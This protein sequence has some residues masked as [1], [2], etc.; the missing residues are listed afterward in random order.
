MSNE[1]TK[2]KRGRKAGST[3]SINVSI[4]TLLK[5]LKPSTVIPVRRTWVSNMETFLGVS[6]TEDEK[7]KVEEVPA[8][9]TPTPARVVVPM[10]E[11][12]L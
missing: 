10:V 1:A 8:E 2:Q 9:E 5:H 12:E 11:E 3:D 7:P 6:I 4:E